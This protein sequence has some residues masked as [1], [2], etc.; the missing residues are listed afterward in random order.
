MPVYILVEQIAKGF[1][2]GGDAGLRAEGPQPH[3]VASLNINPV[4][5]EPVASLA[6]QNI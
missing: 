6:L 3:I 5:I 1:I 4:V 2:T